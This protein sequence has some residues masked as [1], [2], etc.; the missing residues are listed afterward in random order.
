LSPISEND[1]KKA[2]NH[3]KL[4]V[5][6]DSHQLRNHIKK[7]DLHQSVLLMMSSGNFDGIH[8]KEFSKELLEAL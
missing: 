5:F 3:S 6:T 2:F 7:L 1:I 4:E 8:L